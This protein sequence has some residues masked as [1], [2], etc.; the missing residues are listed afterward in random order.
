MSSVNVGLIGFGTIGSG[1]AKILIE[2]ADL[3]ENKLGRPINLKKIADL[4]IE[5]PR[6][7]QLPPG[8]LTREVKDVLGDPDIGI[9]IELVGG[10]EP[11]RTFVLEALAAG[12]HVVTANKALLARHGREIFEAAAANH[13]D[14]L[15]EAAVAGAIP[16]IRGLKEGLTAN[17][18]DYLFGILNGTSNYI[19]TKMTREGVEFAQALA[20]A[21]E[22]GYAEADPT[23]DVEG[24]DTAHKL[25]ILIGLAYGL[26]VDLD[27]IHVEGISGLDPID[28]RFAEEFGYVIKLLAISSQDG[29]RIEARVH[30]TMLP[31]DHLLSDVNGVFNAI[32]VHGHAAGDLL[33]YGRGA[34]RMPTAGAVVADVIELARAI[35]TGAAGR[36]PPMSWASTRGADLKPRPMSEVETTYYFRFSALD[37]PGVLSRISGVLGEHRISISAVIQKGREQAGAVPIVML[38]HEARESDVRRALDELDRLD[39]VRGRTVVIRVEDRLR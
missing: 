33:F 35:R 27:D 26:Q 30:P 21:Q 13:V 4:D 9:V 32:H 20:E 19:L 12:K 6:P 14:V 37:K 2:D 15:Y 38:T 17:R 18:I 16:I 34:G 11:A 24:V 10:Y 22:R 7:V 36:V 39:V 1:V 31:A 8:L 29:G 23:F 3:I 5:T 25:A 28:I